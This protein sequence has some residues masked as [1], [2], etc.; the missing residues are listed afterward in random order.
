M[1]P[2]EAKET[3]LRAALRNRTVTQLARDLS[4]SRPTVSAWAYTSSIPSRPNARKLMSLTGITLHLTLFGKPGTSRGCRSAIP[5][6]REMFAE[7]DKRGLLN[8]EIAT[9]AKVDPKVVT[10]LRKGSNYPVFSTIEAVADALG[11]RV[12]LEKK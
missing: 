5:I 8:K 7:A 12:V 3:L 6:V 10:N 4:I 11:F 1:T 2:Q 9:L